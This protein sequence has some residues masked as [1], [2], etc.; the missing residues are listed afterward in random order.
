MECGGADNTVMRRTWKPYYI[1]FM[2]YGFLILSLTLLFL[3]CSMPEEQRSGDGEE[4]FDS[5]P[6]WTDDSINNFWGKQIDEELTIR[7]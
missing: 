6:T 3:S 7:I 2:T 1:S 4:D 5:H